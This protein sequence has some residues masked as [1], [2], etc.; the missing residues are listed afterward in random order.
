MNNT[1]NPVGSKAFLDFEDNVEILDHRLTSDQD[2][3]QDRLGKSRL[4]WAG[5]VRA[6]TGDP[7]VIVPIVQQAVQ[8]VVDG[9]DGQVDRAEG[10]AD[11]AEAAADSAQLRSGLY[12]TVE[13]GLTAAA[14]GG[15]FTVPSAEDSAFITM[16]RKESGAAVF[17]KTYPS[18]AALDGVWWAAETSVE[19]IDT[20][21][22]DNPVVFG[23]LGGDSRSPLN[24]TRDGTTHL[25]ALRTEKVNGNDITELDEW[26]G[27]L[28]AIGGGDGLSPLAIR[29]DGTVVVPRLQASTINGRDVEDLTASEYKLPTSTQE[30]W[31]YPV[32]TMLTAPYPRIVSGVY[33]EQGQIFA[34]ETIPGV[35]V[36]QQ[37]EVGRTPAVDDH[38]A[39]A[40]FAEAGRRFVIAWTRHGGDPYLRIR[41]SDQTG[42]VRSFVDLPEVEIDTGGGYTY[43][44]IFKLP[45]LS[46]DDN[47]VFWVFG[48]H[49]SI[50]WGFLELT[51]NQP[52]G[53]V[54]NTPWQ[55][56][57]SA[58]GYLSI[59]ESHGA[60]ETLRIFLGE[61][62]AND[63]NELYYIEID[64]LTGDIRVPSA[65]ALSANM[66]GTGLPLAIKT[67]TPV[68]PATPPTMSRRLFYSRPGP[69]SPAVL[70]AEWSKENP[71]GAIYKS[72]VLESGAWVIREHGPTGSRFGYVASANYLPGG[73]FPDPC[74]SDLMYLARYDAEQRT[75]VIEEVRA[76]TPRTVVETPGR[77]ARPILPKNGSSLLSQAR[78]TSYSDTSFRFTGE[79]SFS[80]LFEVLK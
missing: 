29:P 77:L 30:W 6:G 43:A 7:A 22:D 80:N 74:G 33:G 66:D 20:W 25:S 53:S 24:V 46:D 1:G 9:V 72:A 36:V 48:R 54:T 10:A 31:I 3:F 62:P 65:P 41:V 79:V 11:R 27:F 4:T 70:Y 58:V 18:S 17:V 57:F 8:D 59:A 63:N 76:G 39:P 13:E 71:D 37:V 49:S 51:V 12:A 15:F 56:L 28:F 16:Y 52:A 23:V 61:N 75:S 55:R 69:V 67:S 64:K 73:S 34:C 40:L 14:E 32:H 38:N 42:D 68:V 47:D 60:T 19:D 45:H 26:D 2:T 35:G 50:G 21:S 78:F 5:I 44:Q